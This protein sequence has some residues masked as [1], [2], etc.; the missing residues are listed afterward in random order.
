M[1]TYDNMQILN[2]D[3]GLKTLTYEHKVTHTH[4]ID[5]PIDITTGEL[6]QGASLLAFLHDACISEQEAHP[7][8][9][10]D[11]E[12]VEVFK[13]TFSINLAEEALAE[14]FADDHPPVD[15]ILDTLTT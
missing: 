11:A 12:A 15:V 3:M 9:Q 8:G 1:N 14:S 13:E 7:F 4:T 6:L 10:L 5:H 2:Y